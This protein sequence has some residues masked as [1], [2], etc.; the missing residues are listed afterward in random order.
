MKIRYR[1]IKNSN[2]EV[3]D[4]IERLTSETEKESAF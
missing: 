1:R 3:V 4:K 2:G